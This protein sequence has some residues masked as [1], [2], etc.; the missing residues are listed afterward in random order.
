M[1]NDRLVAALELPVNSISFEFAEAD[2]Q[3]CVELL[4]LERPD[5]LSFDLALLQ[6]VTPGDDRLLPQLLR[7]VV[8]NLTHNII[9]C[10]S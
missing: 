3:R 5:N 8:V 4:E 10:L 2:G 9:L 1:L 7:V 6:I